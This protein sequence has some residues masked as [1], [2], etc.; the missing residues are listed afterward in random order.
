MITL[1]P[2]RLLTYLVGDA[3]TIISCSLTLLYFF[4][5]VKFSVSEWIA[6]SA[7]VLLW[8]LIEYWLKLSGRA[9]NQKFR[10]RVVDHFKAYSIFIAVI[11][12]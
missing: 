9:L 2:R 5:E 11:F 6:L 3:L 8:F 12:F 4:R 10:A 1:K 7:F